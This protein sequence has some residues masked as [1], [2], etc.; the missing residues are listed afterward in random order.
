MEQR[1]DY[2]NFN[3]FLYN[4]IMSRNID[5]LPQYPNF[6]NYNGLKISPQNFELLKKLSKLTNFSIIS[7]LDVIYKHEYEKIQHISKERDKCSI[8]LYEFYDDIIQDNNRGELILK[9]MYEYMNHE[10][11]TIKLLKC[12]DHFFHIECLSNYIQEKEGFKCPNCQTIYGL[13]LGSM[14]PGTFWVEVKDNMHCQ[15][16]PKD[17]TIII[18]YHF[19]SGRNYSG[20]SRTCYLPN[21]EKGR[22]VLALLKIAF[23]RKLTFVIGTSVTTGQ[24]NTVVWNGIHHKTSMSGGATNFGY[25]DDNY[26]NRV[27]EELAAKGVYRREGLQELALSVMYGNL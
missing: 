23:D 14:P 27:E 19:D 7:P 5:Q 4:K 2:M 6:S 11:D 1:I 12:H 16:F 22:D 17:G 20:T 3:I 25:P 21:N 26:F 9:N 8:C 18:H 15:G 10:I 13:F 24:K